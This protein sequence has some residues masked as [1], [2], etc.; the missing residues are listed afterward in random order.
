[1]GASIMASYIGVNPPQQTGIVNRFQFTATA[2]QTVFTGA[3]ANGVTLFYISSNPTLVFLNGVQLVVNTDYTQT[4]NDTITLAS[5]ATVNDEVE[6]MG[7]GSFD[8][9]NAATTRSQLGLGTAA[10]KDVGTGANNVVQLNG[11]SALPAVDGSNLTGINTDVVDDTTPQLGGNLDTND[12]NIITVSNRDIN[13]YPNGTGAVEVGGNTN[14]GTLILNCEANSHGIKLQSPPHSASQSYTLKFPTGNVTADRFLK[15]AS[16]TGSGATA[17]GQLSFA[18]VSAGISWQAVKTANFTAVAQEGY[19][20]NTTSGT[21]AVTLPSSPS[22]G[23]NVAIVDYAGTFNTNN[24]SILPNGNKI[25]G[26]TN[27]QGLSTNRVAINLTYIDSTQGWLI[28]S[29]GSSTPITGPVITWN[30][31]SG[32]L[33]TITDAQRSGGFSLSSA[34]ASASIG[35]PT[36]SVTSGSLPGGLS[37][38]SSTGA[39]TGTVTNPVS[40]STTSN[41]TVTA[42]ISN[43]GFTETRNFSITV[44]APIITF[45]TAAGTLGTV[46][47]GSRSNGNYTLSPVTATTTSGSLTYAVTTGSLPA[48][49]SLNSSTGAITGN[50]DA[51]GSNTTTQFTITATET[52][53][54]VTA[55]RQFSI[56]VQA[57]IVVDFLVIAGGAAGGTGG[58]GGSASVGGA[59]GGGAGG[60]RNS[61]NNE[62]SGGGGSSESSLTLIAGT[63]YTI[64]VGGGGSGSGSIDQRGNS[65]N[66]SVFS[67][68]TSTG[69]GGGGSGNDGTGNS[70]GLSGGSG[71]GGGETAGGGSGTSGQG[72]S[73]SSGAGNNNGG[74]GAGGAGS[75]GGAGSGNNGGNGGNGVASSINGSSVTRAGGG[76]GGANTTATPGSG[77]SGGGGAGGT[78]A[79]HGTDNTGS[80]GG[81]ASDRPNRVSGNGGSGLVILRLPTAVY[82]GTTTGSPSV[83]TSGSD[84]ILTYTGSGSY[85]A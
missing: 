31:A 43:F 70:G 17:V 77:G 84:T 51:V 82:S 72:F 44:Q 1:M 24:C 23:D 52:S 5:G 50:F 33:G 19:A 34:G 62:T 12:K 81:G 57:P 53:S 35:T 46:A 3:D 64:T 78:T 21:V 85:T 47:D 67:S 61:Y 15:V 56:T 20:V 32:T 41:F 65:G 22:V 4:D 42:S 49:V 28:T 8:L 25:E 40:T 13:L 30:T 26:S 16:I 69:G 36:F 11:S 2:N 74:G 80:G 29:E 10:T 14:P 7:F 18:E 66:N 55:A 27:A 48:S 79:G 39:I 73:G 75:S 54:S 68:I 71:G 45:A 37:I 59:G 76:G 38:V 6:I 60:Y 63:Q 83:S 58:T 9:N